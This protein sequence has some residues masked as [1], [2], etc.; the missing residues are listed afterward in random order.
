MVKMTEIAKKRVYRTSEI[1]NIAGIHVNTVRFY[2]RIQLI[3]PV[4][5]KKN[6]YREYSYQH[7]AQVLVLR[8]LFL[9]EWPGRAVRD[10]S[11]RIIDAMKAWN[12]SLAKTVASEYKDIVRLERDKTIKTLR[13]LKDWSSQN[14]TSTADVELDYNQTAELI[15]VTK[16]TIRGWERNRLVEIPRRDPGKTRYFPT[17][18]C[19]RLQVIYLL[20]QARFSL[21]AIYTALKSLDQG[22]NETAIESLATPEKDLVYTSGDHVLEVLNKTLD[23]A[24]DLTAFVES[25]A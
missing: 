8:Y 16:E 20:R 7:L 6:N 5:R 2:E 15:G 19:Q 14:T 17:Q 23:K 13:I 18:V 9:D 1:A 12:L 21:S 25:L 11:Y 22:D 24:E 10:A 3:S 4:P